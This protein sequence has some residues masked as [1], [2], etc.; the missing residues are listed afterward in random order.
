MPPIPTWYK[1]T[2]IWIIPSDWEVLELWDLW[3]FS[4][5]KWIKKDEVKKT[6]LPSVRY[7]ELYTKFWEK[8]DIVNS[9]ISLETAKSSKVISKW[10]ILFA[11]SGETKEEIWKCGVLSWYDTAYAG[12]D[13][14][15]LTPQ[16][17]Y[18]SIF[19]A[20]CLNTNYV[21]VQ[22]SQF[23][24]GD[25]VV[26]LY[27]SWLGKVN[28]LFP[29]NK[30][31]QQAIATALS[32]IDTCIS[33]L[34][35]LITKHQQIKKG[36]MQQLL[37]G[38]KRLPGFDGE[39]EEVELWGNVTITTGRKDVNQWSSNWKYPFFTCSKKLSYSNEYSFEWKA[40]L[41]AGN[42]EVGHLQYYDWKFEAYQ[43]T[44]VLQ[45]FDIDEKYL[46]HQLVR[47]FKKSLGIGTIWST[48]PYIKKENIYD[49]QVLSPKDP[50]EQQAIA[51]VLS[52]IDTHIHNLQTKKKKY[53]K[54]KR[55]MMQK[56]LTGQIR[57]V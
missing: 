38:K 4:K 42:W 9:Y 56:L 20:Y 35:A 44:Y 17:K 8:I 52:D 50:K 23:A 13:I 2:D 37:T 29:K 46:W 22:K 30:K 41:I 51:Q 55:W 39:W 40:I 45:Y 3:S 15:I 11:W 57:L 25:A 19:L 10:D 7:W 54:I 18:D 34:D 48:I 33:K 31:E 36:T 1:Q 47:D 43:R 49:Y 12:W 14:I 21:Q 6:W 27:S 32:D 24:Q 28:V 53:E 26:H 16:K 5:W